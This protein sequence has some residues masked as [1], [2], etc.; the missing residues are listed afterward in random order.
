[1]ALPA[2]ERGHHHPHIARRRVA[3]GNAG[4]RS[5]VRTL[6]LAEPANGAHPRTADEGAGPRSTRHADRP[7]VRISFLQAGRSLRCPFWTANRPRARLTADGAGD[8][9]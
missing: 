5:T 1:M 6:L 9:A 7:V 3:A 2:C 8:G 4:L